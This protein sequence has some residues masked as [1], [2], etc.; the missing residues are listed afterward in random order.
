MKTTRIS[1]GYYQGTYRGHEF[2]L[3]DIGQHFGDPIGGWILPI[4]GENNAE[5]RKTKKDA[6]TLAMAIIDEKEEE[7]HAAIIDS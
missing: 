6:I 5:P 4:D 7:R 2:E 3:I 1:R